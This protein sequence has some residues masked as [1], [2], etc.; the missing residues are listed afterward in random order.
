MEK[1]EPIGAGAEMEEV[2]C[3]EN[4]PCPGKFS[5]F[6]HYFIH[7]FAISMRI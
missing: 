1:I 4:S 3:A 7:R 2:T 5:F 6:V